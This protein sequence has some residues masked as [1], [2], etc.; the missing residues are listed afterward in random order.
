MHH[1]KKLTDARETEGRQGRLTLIGQAQSG[2]ATCFERIQGSANQ[3]GEKSG[4][5]RN[6]GWPGKWGVC[7]FMFLALSA[8]TFL[9]PSDVCLTFLVVLEGE[10]GVVEKCSEKGGKWQQ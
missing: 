10:L 8:Q 2:V 7:F 4:V 5:A 3:G 6:Q 1:K 9:G